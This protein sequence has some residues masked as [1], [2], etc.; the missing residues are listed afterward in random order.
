MAYAQLR[1]HPELVAL[2]FI[3]LAASLASAPILFYG[4]PFG[5]DTIYHQSWLHA[6]NAELSA[7]EWYPRWL[8]QLNGGAGSPGFFFYGPVP[9]YIAALFNNLICPG[10]EPATVGT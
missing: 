1:R 4:A 8:H 5:Q 2:F 7:G 3:L 6:F 9:F 10:C